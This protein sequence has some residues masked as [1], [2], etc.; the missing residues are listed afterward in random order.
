M[1]V[2]ASD[3]DDIYDTTPSGGT[4]TSVQAKMDVRG[5]QA[6]DNQQEVSVTRTDISPSSQLRYRK[7]YQIG[8]IVSVD[9]NFG[10]IETRR[11]IEYVEIDENGSTTGHP[12]LA[13]IPPNAIL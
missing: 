3:I 13:D 5:R 11:I 2:D 4:L 6:L 9:G 8:D 7:D 10:E 1:L 12:T